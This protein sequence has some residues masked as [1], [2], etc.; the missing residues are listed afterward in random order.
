[1]LTGR[2][3]LPAADPAWRDLLLFYEYFDGDTGAAA[4]G[5]SH[6]TGWTAADRQPAGS[7]AAIRGLL[8]AADSGIRH[9]RTSHT[10][11]PDGRKAFSVCCCSAASLLLLQEVL[12]RHGDRLLL[13]DAQLHRRQGLG[14]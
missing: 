5:A 13:Q 2:G 3:P 7:V 6:Q 4:L 8:R 12:L 11:C 9:R 1:M 10:Y 14:G